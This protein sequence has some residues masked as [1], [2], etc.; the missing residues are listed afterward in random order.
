MHNDGWE[1]LSYGRA[2]AA[3]GERDEARSYLEAALR[4]D[5]HPDDQVEAWYWLSQ[6]TDD[7]AAQRDCLE[8]VLA[9]QPGH[10]AARRDLAILDGRLRP[11]DLVDHRRPVAPV[12]PAP[13]VAPEEIR[14]YFC[15]QCGGKLA[16]DPARGVLRCELCR[17]ELSAQ[18]PRVAA[19]AVA[20][21]DWMQAVH[22]ERGHR[23]ELPVARVLHCQ[24]CGAVVTLPPSRVSDTCPFCD[25]AHVV[26]SAASRDLIGPEG[27]IPFGFP[28]E[29]VLNHAHRWLAAQRFRPG[30]LDARAT[31]VRPRPIYL[32]FWTFDL[33]GAIKWAGYIERE[34]V[35]RQ[36][37]RMPVDGVILADCD[38]LLVP[39]TNSLAAALLGE[40]RYDTR[41]TIPYA[42]DLL[43]DWPAEIYRI[44]V[45]DASLQ[46]RT[47]AQAQDIAA[48]DKGI[49]PGIIE[50]VQGVTVDR[51]GL[52]V[53]SYKLLLAPVWVT[54]YGYKGE[55]YP[56][57]VNGQTG[58][59]HGAVPRNAVRQLLHGLFGQE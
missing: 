23:W 5:L 51:S 7:R 13:T 35:G 19:H 25:S 18:D 50:E 28:V 38:D 26:E 30:D 3:A 44:P 31:F 6:V 54:E 15:T 58:R 24:A 22:T 20:E 45:A 14:H 11:A 2:A 17:H 52:L 57:L 4:R 43:A 27:V 36:R 9:L 41:G 46:A 29:A 34:T 40:L 12:V 37:V 56:L 39:A 49:A 16:F 1:M 55:R 53:L 8:S 59:G 33:S 48:L 42:P 32:P 21:Q 10:G 47:L